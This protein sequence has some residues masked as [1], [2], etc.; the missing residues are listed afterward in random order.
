VTAARIARLTQ[1]GRD[2]FMDYQVPVA[3]L[4]L[5]QGFG[6]LIRTRRDAGIV[7]ILD[8]R[9]LTRGYGQTLLDA[10]PPAARLATLDE[11]RAFWAMLDPGEP[12]PPAAAQTR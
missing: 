1:Q 8:R 9:L 5:K 6:R 12:S 3:A 7:S 4:A 11:V 10:L 2:P